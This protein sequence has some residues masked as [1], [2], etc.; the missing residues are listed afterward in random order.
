[1]ARGA[2]VSRVRA[3]RDSTHSQVEW[4]FCFLEK[5]KDNAENAEDSQRRKGLTQRAQRK[6]HRGHREEKA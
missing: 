1:V 3:K 4:V 2:S 5:R 6:A